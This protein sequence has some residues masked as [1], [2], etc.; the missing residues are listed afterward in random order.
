LR[1]LIEATLS[2][3]DLRRVIKRDLSYILLLKVFYLLNK[4]KELK[5]KRDKDDKYHVLF[6]NGTRSGPLEIDKVKN[7]L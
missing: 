7:S 3:K 1:F 2:V 4:K 6:E 5:V